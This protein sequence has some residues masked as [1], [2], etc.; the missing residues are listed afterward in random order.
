MAPS[1]D[2]QRKMARA[3]YDRQMARRAARERRRRRIQ[4]GVGAG[5]AVVLIAVGVAWLGGVFDSKPDDPTAADVCAWTPQSAESNPDLKDVGTPPTSGLPTSGTEAMTVTTNQGDPIVVD[6]DLTSAPCSAAS[7]RYL[8]SK[9]FY[10]N[11][12]CYEITTEGALHC[13]DPSG[14]G[15][16]GPTYSFYDENVPPAPAPSAS[17]TPDAAPLY[18]TGTVALTGVPPGTNGSQFLIFLKDYDPKDP[19][20]PIVGTVSSGMDTV[21]K[22]GKIPTVD[23]G[24]GAEVKPKEKVV[25]QSLTVGAAP[26]PSASTA[27]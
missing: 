1:K 3:K 25:V 2:R 20:Y 18:P 22:I 16:G 7:L 26:A 21:T 10:D 19:Q 5:V 14:T 12:E 8:A 4:A 27:S 11:T 15:Q 9:N 13:G 17:A 24:S 6:L 23:N